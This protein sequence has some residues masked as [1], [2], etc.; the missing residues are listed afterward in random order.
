MLTLWILIFKQNFVKN[1]QI[2]LLAQ[3][4]YNI[5]YYRIRDL[6]YTPVSNAKTK[7]A[8]LQ[9]SKIN[10]LNYNAFK[11]FLDK[12]VIINKFNLWFF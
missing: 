3:T 4:Q 6:S 8:D 2:I 11:Q 12:K 1:Y 5:T 10:Y 9:A 7:A